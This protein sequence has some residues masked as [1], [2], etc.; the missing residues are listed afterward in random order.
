VAASAITAGV[1]EAVGPTFGNSFGGQVATRFTSGLVAQA[2]TA[3]GGKINV[4]QIAADAFGSAIGNAIVG[5]ITQAGQQEQRLQYTEDLRDATMGSLMGVAS[6]A[7]QQ[8][9]FNRSALL[10][11][12]R[13]SDPDY[14]APNYSHWPDQTNAETARLAIYEDM[15]RPTPE[16]SQAAFRQMER[17]YRQATDTGAVIRRGDNLER[18]AGYSKEMMGR[19]AS[20]M[21]LRNMNELP[22]GQTMVA[23]WNMSASH[24]VAKANQFYYTDGLQKTAASMVPAGTGGTTVSMDDGSFLSAL[25]SV[26]DSGIL[27]PL[28]ARTKQA[29]AV[30]MKGPQWVGGPNVMS[31]SDLVASVRANP[32]QPNAFQQILSAGNQVNGPFSNFVNS[33]IASTGDAI[34]GYRDDGYNPVSNQYYSLTERDSAKWGMVRNSALFAI[35]AGWA[36]QETVALRATSGTTG[37]NGQSM[38]SQFG[39]NGTVFSGHGSYEI[40]SGMVVVPEGTSLTVYSKFGSTI[41]DRLGNIIETGGDLS[42]VYKRTYVAGEKLPNYTLHAPNGLSIQGNPFTVNS[43]TP[44]TDLLMPGMGN[45]SWAA[46]TY[47]WRAPNSNLVFDT[48]GIANKQSKQ[49]IT[50]YSNTTP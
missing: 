12:N 17:D 13:A 26:A 19:Y 28:D 9:A 31:N 49:W 41:T 27:S 18:L 43:P 11:S 15:A 38:N 3:K 6:A 34:A 1:A 36:A 25:R 24:A 40:G 7:E 22:V 5:Q 23:N 21:G 30:S 50:I 35:P 45:C 10:A 42:N 47:N 32:G 8:Q 2:V 46:C 39:A 16:A 14:Y 33:F 44:L 29:Y 20:G 4:G 37:A 48:V